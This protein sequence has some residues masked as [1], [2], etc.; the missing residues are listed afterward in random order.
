[1]ARSDGG[2]RGSDCASSSATRKACGTPGCNKNQF[3]TGLCTADLASVS[4]SRRVRRIL[5]EDVEDDDLA[6]QLI[7]T[8]PAHLPENCKSI[9]VVQMTSPKV[10]PQSGERKQSSSTTK[11]SSRKR[12]T[13]PSPE[14]SDSD[15]EYVPSD[16]E[17][18]VE[19]D[20]GDDDYEEEEEASRKQASLRT[21]TIK[22]SL[23]QGIACSKST[24]YS[25]AAERDVFLVLHMS[26]VFIFPFAEKAK[27]WAGEGQEQERPPRGRGPASE[28]F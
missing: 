23:K 2:C 20:S 21:A 18:E 9:S 5:C 4:K 28:C 12:R 15:E 19:D 16:K 17:D 26:H 14:E 25:N 7:A 11:A 8:T 6:P 3:H 24:S 27:S 22:A 1:M 13:R 10:Q